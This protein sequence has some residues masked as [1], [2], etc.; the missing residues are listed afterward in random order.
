MAPLLVREGVRRDGFLATLGSR[1]WRAR[2]HAASVLADP[3]AVSGRAAY[4]AWL[5]RTAAA[6]ARLPLAVGTGD[7][8]WPL[9]SVGPECL[10]GHE[11]LAADLADL[12]G[13]PLPVRRQAA[14]DD[15]FLVGAAHVAVVAAGDAAV[16]ADAASALGAGPDGP[17]GTRFVVR[18]REL[19]RSRTALRRELAAWA[20]DRD[21]DTAERAVLA[22]QALTLELAD[23]LLA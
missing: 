21:P 6:W 16:L 22:A 5:H 1:T 20:A 2:A 3:Q 19:A 4:A 7:Q 23:A 12:G 9:L 8:P 17:V 10:G 11:E 14:V 15:A 13:H 18:C